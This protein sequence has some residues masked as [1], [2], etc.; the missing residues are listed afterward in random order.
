MIDSG[1]TDTT[2]GIDV[3]GETRTRATV[4][5]RSKTSSRVPIARERSA[6]AGNRRATNE[7]AHE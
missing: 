7:G 6:P 1:Q 2:E 5:T 3:W 4:S